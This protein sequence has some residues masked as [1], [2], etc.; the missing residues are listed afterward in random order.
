MFSNRDLF[1]P[2]PIIWQHFEDLCWDI[3]GSLLGISDTQKYG[4]QGQSQQ[5]IDILNFQIQKGE[6]IGIQCKGKDQYPPKKFTK[7]ELLTSVEK[8]KEFRPILSK[9][10][11]AT[12]ARRD[13]NIQRLSAEIT[14]Q[15]YEK[16]LFSVQVY[17]WDDIQDLFSKFPDIYNNYYSSKSLPY[18]SVE[19]VSQDSSDIIG[20]TELLAHQNRII[21]LESRSIVDASSL[22]QETLSSEFKAELDEIKKLLDSS[23]PT[24]ANQLLKSLKDRIWIKASPGIKYRIITNEAV[25]NFQLGN[26]PEGGRLLIE[27]FQYNPEDEKALGNVAFGYLINQNEEKAIEYS[28]KVI[29]KNL[30]SPRA[31][32]IIIQSKAKKDSIE[33]IIPTIPHEIINT[34]DVAGAFG[35]CYYNSGNFT[36]ASKWFEIAVKNA[37]ENDLSLKGLWASSL[38]NAVKNDEKII[39]GLQIS[40]EL[41]KFLLKSIELFTEIW[42]RI[43][44]DINFKKAH[45]SW[46]IERGVANRLLGFIN[47]SSKNIIEAYTIK[48]DEPAIIHL[49]GLLEYEL[50]HYP[51]AESL[52]KQVIWSPSTPN[53]LWVYLSSLRKQ[54]KFEEGIKKITEFLIEQKS[55][56]QEDILYHFL[57]AFNFDKGKENYYIAKSI[58][59][60]RFEENEKDITRA[61]QLAKV[62]GYIG[63]L[64]EFNLLI[65]KIKDLY[66]DSLPP[67]LQLDIAELFFKSQNFE[68][69]VSIYEK[70]IDS[71]QDTPFTHKLIDALYFGGFHKRALEICQLLHSIHGLLPHSSYIE[72]AIY[73]E[74]GDLLAAK[75]ISTEYLVSFPDEFEMKLNLAI[76]NFHL[77]NIQDVVNFIEKPIEFQNLT[78]SCG[79]KL[80]GLLYSLGKFDDAISLSY[81]LRQKNYHYPQSHLDYIHLILDIGDRS[82]LLTKPVTIS[83]N[84]TVQLE[85]QS[86]DIANYTLNE[87]SALIHESNEILINGDLGNKL[88]DK[89]EGDSIILYS[90]PINEVSV[91]IK[92]IITKYIF[93]F[94]DSI[95]HFNQLFPEHPGIYR[96][97]F[98]KGSNGKP[99][100]EDIQTIKKLVLH[101]QKK[102]DFIFDAYKAGHLTIASMAENLGLDIFSVCSHIS[103]YQQ[104]GIRCCRG[105]LIEKE[106]IFKSLRN[107]LKLVIDPVALFS[108]HTLKIGDPLV[109]KFEEIYITQSSIDLLQAA[110]LDLSGQK[111]QGYISIF[112]NED[113][114]GFIPTSSE[115]I[116][117]AKKQLQELLD[118]VRLH[119]K[120][121]P[122][123][124]SLNLNSKEKEKYNS[125]IGRASIDSIL[126]ASQIDYLLYTDDAILQG[127]ADG[128]YSV[129]FSW[130]QVLLEWLLLEKVITQDQYEEFTIQIISNNYYHTSINSNILL[131]SAIVSNWEEKEPFIQVL[132][133]I[134]EGYSNIDSS[135]RVGIGFTKLLW[136]QSI[137]LEMKKYFLLK[138]LKILIDKRDE[139]Y[140]FNV[141]FQ[142]FKND[143]ELTPPIKNE[144]LETI[145]LYIAIF[146]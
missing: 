58:A 126:V 143:S 102:V 140:I 136:N 118:W 40:N 29:E 76:I 37:E 41:Q 80:T 73:N 53:A 31:Y 72:L 98:G 65:S 22:L 4:R 104:I 7:E 62:L 8:A 75:K 45:I 106:T 99:T 39:Q 144:I 56:E 125:L 84:S 51:L 20:K 26:Y 23:N 54:R 119:C 139:K 49:Y 146:Y 103:Q 33:N 88:V 69:A 32:S 12:T 52:A 111:S 13:A 130:T 142:T 85:D 93:A 89:S 9:F 34:Q 30:L 105:D 122:C 48:Q 2:P 83:V 101:N 145:Q 27:A 132:N 91:I 46:L 134:R 95:S 74:V 116:E 92:N 16:G 86:G 36:E 138:L 117:K 108:I 10:I 25:V 17:S 57:I 133:T 82:T 11:I 18:S 59:T 120:I 68:D 115:Q 55:R 47:E 127:V 43:P 3:F 90:T 5:G 6:W 135:I 61:I 121:A 77:G 70:I 123:Y 113:T 100:P 38:L 112:L 66:E 79:S 141:F 97:P 131:K 109:E 94:Q 137:N 124:E 24:T 67:I 44:D 42:N 50:G 14:K 63:E 107:G 78:Y 114:L 21:T 15:H 60:S 71:S 96:I 35:Q 1:I 128:L 64:E 87:E 110:I 81:Y 19:K 28:L 129:K